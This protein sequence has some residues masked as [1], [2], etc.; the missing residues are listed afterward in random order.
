M[1]ITAT[2]YNF[3]K[4]K[5]DILLPSGGSDIAIDVKS[6]CTIENP[7]IELDYSGRPPFNY[8]YIPDF[9]RYYF[10]TGMEYIEGLWFVSGKVD[11]LNSFKTSILNTKANVL[12]ANVD[13]NIVDNRI[14]VVSAPVVTSDTTI[15]GPVIGVYTYVLAVTGKGSMGYYILTNPNDIYDL[16]DGID[17]TTTNW[18]DL[19]DAAKQA[20]YGGS[21]ADNIKSIIRFP[22]QIQLDGVGPAE[23]LYLGGYPAKKS[24]GSHIS[25]NKV[26]KPI[27]SWNNSIAI[28]WHF[29]DWRRNPPYTKIYLYLPLIGVIELDTASLVNETTIA[30]TYSF[31]ITS[32]D[33]AFQ[34]TSGSG[35]ILQ[36]G[37]NNIGMPAL[38]GNAGINTGKAFASSAGLAA[39]AVALASG[40]L[41]GGVGAAAVMGM[42]GTA[43]A[44]INSLGGTSQGSSGIG[45]GA[46]TGLDKTVQIWVVSRDITSQ[47]S[48]YHNVI[49]YPFMDCRTISGLSGYVRTE[50]FSLKDANAYESEIAEVNA[51]M[52][53]GVYIG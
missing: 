25:V 15:A 36:T 17:D 10:V 41:S 5:N 47:P 19:L 38:Y 31:N 27:Q 52:D 24:G 21:A 11:P 46:V 1:S 8:F 14:P 26:T 23:N 40:M 50:G 20:A 6:G 12:Y 35:R 16:I 28:P 22:V 13:R 29:S 33:L 34:V 9:G 42:V 18:N 32:G 39:G 30:W 37:S 53:G 3:S 2:F 44:L 48:N 51:L 7:V 49:G 43:G 45:G 4:R